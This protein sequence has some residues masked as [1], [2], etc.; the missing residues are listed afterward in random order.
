MSPEYIDVIMAHFDLKITF[1]KREKQSRRPVLRTVN[2]ELSIQMSILVL[3][4][5]AKG[6]ML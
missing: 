1:W 3:S 6:W 4:V 5:L 2:P